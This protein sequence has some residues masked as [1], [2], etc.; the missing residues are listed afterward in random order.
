[1][2]IFFDGKELKCLAVSEI[3]ANF[4]ALKSMQ[5]RRYVV[6]ILMDKTMGG[7]VGVWHPRVKLRAGR[8]K[9]EK[10][11]QRNTISNNT[12]KLRCPVF[13]N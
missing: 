9:N 6:N 3:I 11:E 2:L 1:M 12:N 10:N 7:V 5:T 4:A 13:S 8:H